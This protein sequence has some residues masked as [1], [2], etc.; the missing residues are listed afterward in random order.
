MK[1]RTITMLKRK[2]E[3][4]DNEMGSSDAYN[5]H[6][7]FCWN[8]GRNKSNFTMPWDIHMK[9]HQDV[10]HS[11]SQGVKFSGNIPPMPTSSLLR[12]DLTAMVIAE[13]STKRSGIP[14][15]KASDAKLWE[16][17]LSW[18]RKCDCK[19]WISLVAEQF[20]AWEVCRQV[21]TT[22]ALSLGR[23]NLA[24]SISDC[25]AAKATGTLHQRANPLLKY[26]MWWKERGLFPFPIQEAMVYEYIKSR[27]DDSP[28]GPK[29]LLTSI[30]FALHVFGLSGGE[31]VSKSGRIKG[32]ADSH[33]CRS[34]SEATFDI[35]PD[36]PSRR[37]GFVWQV[38]PGGSRLFS[39][40]YLWALEV[41]RRSIRLVLEDPWNL[42][43]GQG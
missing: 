3:D 43:G 31:V 15:A 39:S 11:F 34:S 35:G 29:S 18:E 30:S 28:S 1:L 38:R 14:L 25:L 26:V 10:V 32:L 42:F 6:L 2:W 41:F 20:T 23:G 5:Q 40:A 22:D 8:Q 24:D 4:G 19:K 21:A 16:Q 13:D 27:P 9:T 17:K 7:A 33:F 37:G 36:H 12:E